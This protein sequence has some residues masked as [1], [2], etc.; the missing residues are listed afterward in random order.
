MNVSSLSH[1]T[2]FRSPFLPS[3]ISS[4][5]LFKRKEKGR[6]EREREEKVMMN[7]NLYISS[8]RTSRRRRKNTN[9]GHFQS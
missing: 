9:V 6:E 7:D 1:F 3:I 8:F 2:N 4:K 5:E